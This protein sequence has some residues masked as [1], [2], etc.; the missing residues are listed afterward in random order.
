MYTT[1]INNYLDLIFPLSH[2]CR[3]RYADQ[4][5]QF[6]AKNVVPKAIVHGAESG[7]NRKA[8]L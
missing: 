8:F 2:W 7:N 3:F 6:M 1:C 5:V 4:A